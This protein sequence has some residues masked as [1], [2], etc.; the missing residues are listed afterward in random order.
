MQSRN[1]EC[2]QSTGRVLPTKFYGIVMDVIDVPRKIN[3][4]L[5]LMFSNTAVD[6]GGHECIRLLPAAVRIRS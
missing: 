4:I 5:D 2:G 6:S 1:V 3:L